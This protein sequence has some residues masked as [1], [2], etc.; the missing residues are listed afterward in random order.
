M[1]KYVLHDFCNFA[2]KFQ[3]QSN[4]ETFVFMPFRR[5]GHDGSGASEQDA[6]TMEHL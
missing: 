6:R 1:P 2:I 5:H 3:N 4:E